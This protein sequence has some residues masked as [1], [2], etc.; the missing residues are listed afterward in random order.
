MHRHSLGGTVVKLTGF[1][2]RVI[3]VASLASCW[4]DD[5]SDAPPLPPHPD[6]VTFETKRL[7]VSVQLSPSLPP[8]LTS[9]ITH[10]VSAFGESAPNTILPIPVSEG[11]GD[12]I[13]IA[14]DAAERFMLAA[15]T[16]SSAVLDE[17]TTSIA[18]SRL[19]LGPLPDQ[20]S[21]SDAN[22]LI[23]N[24]NEFG[25]LVDLV[26]HAL[27]KSVSPPTDPAIVE[28]IGRIL[29][30]IGHELPTRAEG[31][32]AAMAKV[33]TFP[34]VAT[35]F[36]YFL[37]GTS[38]NAV[39]I[40]NE[41]Y[42]LSNRSLISWGISTTVKNESFVLGG[43]TLASAILG[44]PK[45]VTLANNGGAGFNIIIG[46]DTA[47]KR[48]NVFSIG[49]EVFQ[50]VLGAVA[51]SDKVGKCA[52]EAGKVAMLPRDVDP[53]VTNPS[54]ETL[55]AYLGNVVTP[56]NVIEIIGECANLSSK[57]NIVPLFLKLIVGASAGY[58][59]AAA[60]AGAFGMFFQFVQF[61]SALK[62]QQQTIGVCEA[63]ESGVPHIVNCP[64]YFRLEPEPTIVVGETALLNVIAFDITDV[65]TSRP[66][67]LEFAS[68]NPEVATVDSAA[69]RVRGEKQGVALIKITD[70]STG[71][72]SLGLVKVV[73]HLPPLSLSHSGEKT[74]STVYI[75]A[76]QSLGYTECELS[77]LFRLVCSG[78]CPSHQEAEYTVR[79]SGKGYDETVVEGIRI[80]EWEG[81]VR[82]SVTID[83][84][85][86]E[87][88]VNASMFGTSIVWN[89]LLDPRVDGMSNA[90]GWFDGTVTVQVRNRITGQTTSASIFFNTR[91]EFVP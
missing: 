75:S 13:V 24:S 32:A 2:L 69:G 23:Q 63:L 6:R 17:R 38:L 88:T 58:F 49:S 52:A 48:A 46:Q 64:S 87:A 91:T 50:Q 33:V 67:F 8:T 42:L 56:S 73:E 72:S 54:T 18:L 3:L 39:E 53:V 37:V 36:P 60:A 89:R 21:P 10:V 1:I 5:P 55:W 66:H 83:P 30:D 34:S 35:P 41:N 59:E 15:M 85:A 25:R 82:G 77:T 81:G 31:R 65:R 4:S 79:S 84:V 40:T 14:V 28:Q 68:Q 9:E 26:K 44:D 86:K 11:H 47:S 80:H 74:C 43:T 62:L 90:N 7:D 20:L 51:A 70:T 45:S 12:T 57:E 71:R 78:G 29:I 22:A 16:T 61:S 27:D 19:A 76:D